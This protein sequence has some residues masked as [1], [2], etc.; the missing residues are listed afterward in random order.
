MGLLKGDSHS[1]A[2]VLVRSRFKP[3]SLKAMTD[4]DTDL[5]LEITNNTE[6]E[7]LASVTVTVPNGIGFDNIAMQRSK[8]VRL[9]TVGK[10][11]TKEV[12][13]RIQSNTASRMGIYKVKVQVLTHYRSYDLIENKFTKV[14]DLR[15]N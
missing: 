1:S 11:E 12:V 4:S 5:V 9:G 2:P 14:L 15:V 13:Y 7:F 8:E 6:K 3:Y 10:G